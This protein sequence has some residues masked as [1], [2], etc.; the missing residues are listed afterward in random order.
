VCCLEGWDRDV[1]YYFERFG[2]ELRLFSAAIILQCKLKLQR[3][4][5]Q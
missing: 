2:N 5:V 1:R 3:N 4:A